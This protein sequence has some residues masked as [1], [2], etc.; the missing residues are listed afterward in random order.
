M[1][2]RQRWDDGIGRVWNGETDALSANLPN[3]SGKVPEGSPF[4]HGMSVWKGYIY[5]TDD[6]GG[7]IAP[8][9]RVKI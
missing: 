1:R 3:G 6:I 8:V 9:C 7:G 5:W 2:P 4:P